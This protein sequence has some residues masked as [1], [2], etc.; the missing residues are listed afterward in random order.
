VTVLEYQQNQGKAATLNH[1]IAHV[2]SDVI[3]FSDANS[4]FE[5]DAIKELVRWFTD[6]TVTA[7]CGRLVICDPK[8]GRNVDSL[9]WRYETFIKRSE[10]RLHEVL[11]ANGAIYALRRDRFVPIPPN[12]IIDDFVI[13][14]LSRI[15]HGGHVI[16]EPAA[17]AHEESPSRIRDEF[18]RRVRIG[19]GAFQALTL[20][21]P[22]LAPR[23]GWMAFSFLS[24]KV[25]RW[26]SPFF[27]LAALA[28]N[29]L[30]LDEPLYRWTFAGQS[31]FYGVA[32]AGHFLP[33][34]GLSF[35][36]VRLTT[37]LAGMNLALLIGFLRFVFVPQ[38]GAWKRTARAATDAARAAPASVRGV[39]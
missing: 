29:L 27:L 14:L 3:V 20:L 5:S 32:L 31:L 28:T 9:Y 30:L 19:A 1:A 23:N 26:L 13:P 2:H 17:V 33:A 24:H 18:W 8:T 25:L 11:G 4:E 35:R 10:G 37:M 21:Y 36:L 15:H 6:P 7:V 34:R 12:T 39:E 22:L 16:Y 38:T